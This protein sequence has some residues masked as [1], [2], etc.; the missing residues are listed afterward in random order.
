MHGDA[1]R[2]AADGLRGRL[3]T[4]KA[5]EPTPK[6]VKILTDWLAWLAMTMDDIAD[7]ARKEK[8]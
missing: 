1:I 6:R 8:L 7:M 4:F 3:A 2:S 5:G